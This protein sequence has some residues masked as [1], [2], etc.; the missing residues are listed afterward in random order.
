M[1]TVRVAAPAQSERYRSELQ[2]LIE[3]FMRQQQVPAS[4]SASSRAA[5]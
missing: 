5:N 4:L 3:D 1:I 2:P